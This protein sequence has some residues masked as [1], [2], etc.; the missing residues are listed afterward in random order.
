M[1]ISLQ[2]KKI[3]HLEKFKCVP[4]II[5]IKNFKEDI[6]FDLQAI[7]FRVCDPESTINK[8][9][10]GLFSLSLLL[11]YLKKIFFFFFL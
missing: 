9:K 7:L 11:F 6:V 10:Q 1:C 5:G 4:D 3:F 8:F 2:N